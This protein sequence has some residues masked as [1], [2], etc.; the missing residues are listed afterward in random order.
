MQRFFFHVVNDTSATMDEDGTLLPDLDAACKEA[1]KIIGAI[2]AD[3]LREG[4]DVLHLAVM[5]D[6]AH[7]HRVGK[8]ATVTQVTTEATAR[9]A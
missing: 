5:I 2:I 9:G 1:R 3:E 6:D 4:R 8:V 7:G